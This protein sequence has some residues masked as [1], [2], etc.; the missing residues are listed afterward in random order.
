[1]LLANHLMDDFFGTDKAP[2]WQILLLNFA[3]FI[4]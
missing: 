3:F 4:H 1:M 2:T